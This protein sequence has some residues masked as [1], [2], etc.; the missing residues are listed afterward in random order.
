MHSSIE[1]LGQN[2]RKN[3]EFTLHSAFGALLKIMNSVLK[4]M[5]NFQ[6]LRIA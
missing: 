5:L 4:Q 3:L 1:M 2:S 6:T